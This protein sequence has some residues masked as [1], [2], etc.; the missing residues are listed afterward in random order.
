MLGKLT[1]VIEPTPR[2]GQTKMKVHQTKMLHKPLLVEVEIPKL[3][4][5]DQE[6]A[7]NKPILDLKLDLDQD[8]QTAAIMLE[9]PETTFSELHQSHNHLN[10]NKTP[11][12]P[13][14]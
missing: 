8:P 14:Q 5:A 7:L 1:M 3:Q 10:N 6:P 2:D 12:A 9:T 4:V 13:H 11:V